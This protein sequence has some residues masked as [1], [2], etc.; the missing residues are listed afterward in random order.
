METE[1]YVD[2]VAVGSR[3]NTTNEVSF[4]VYIQFESGRRIFQR[5]SLSVE[6]K[7]TSIREYLHHVRYLGFT[8]TVYQ[9]QSN[10]GGSYSRLRRP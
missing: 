9:F 10:F 4:A 5:D 3:D 6:A 7:R 1:R 8:I 2:V